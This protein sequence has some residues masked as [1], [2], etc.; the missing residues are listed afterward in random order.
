MAK[1]LSL[2]SA[3]LFMVDQA[4]AEARAARARESGQWLSDY[5]SG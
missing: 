3:V 5:V 2:D 1:K 4:N